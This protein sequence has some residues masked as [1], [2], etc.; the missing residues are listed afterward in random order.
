[1]RDT[2]QQCGPTT[3]KD[4]SKVLE[5]VLVSIAIGYEL[6]FEGPNRSESSGGRSAYLLSPL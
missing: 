5:L 6:A 3:P 4:M 2:E 1:M